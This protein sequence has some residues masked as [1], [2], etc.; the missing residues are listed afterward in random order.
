MS[1]R[2]HVVVDSADP[3]ER[4]LQRGRQVGDAVRRTWPIYLAL[5][6]VTAQAYERD[7]IDPYAVA[8][9]CLDATR[10]WSPALVRELEGVAEGVRDAQDNVANRADR[11]RGDR[12]A[13]VRR[14]LAAERTVTGAGAR[15]LAVGDLVTRRENEQGG[16]RGR[17]V[18]EL[19]EDRNGVP[20]CRNVNQHVEFL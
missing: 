1:E 7:P 5:F 3:F 12:G 14:V 17:C 9:A 15:W 20:L 10:D 16:M 4:G 6:D 18:L 2:V 11:P 19:V 8:T 13:H